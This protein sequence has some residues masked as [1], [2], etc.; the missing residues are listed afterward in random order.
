MPLR[1][2]TRQRWLLCRKEVRVLTDTKMKCGKCGGGF[3]RVYRHY[4]TGKLMDA[5]KYG[6][7]AWPFGCRCAKP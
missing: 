7:Q 2:S 1:V 3:I 4:R 5:R 6:Y